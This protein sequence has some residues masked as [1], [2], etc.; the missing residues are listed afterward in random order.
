MA[1]WTNPAGRVRELQDEMAFSRDF[2]ASHSD[3]EELW[4]N[5]LS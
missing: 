2:A 4:E 5:W 3:R 1:S